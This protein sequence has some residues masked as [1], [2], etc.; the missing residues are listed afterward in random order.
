MHSYSQVNISPSLPSPVAARVS[1]TLRAELRPQRVTTTWLCNRKTRLTY[2]VSFSRRLISHDVSTV[3]YLAVPT[4]LPNCRLRWV[5]S[6]A[7]CLTP[8]PAHAP[9]SRSITGVGESINGTDNALCSARTPVGCL[10]TSA[11]SYVTR[12]VRVSCI[13]I[14][15]HTATNRSVLYTL[16]ILIYD[17]HRKETG[18]GLLQSTQGCTW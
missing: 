13:S 15:A 16:I 18:Q 17:M 10:R 7:S 6:A 12:S 1:A 3:C 9:T 14:N 4:L 11:L 8:P 5:R 2:L